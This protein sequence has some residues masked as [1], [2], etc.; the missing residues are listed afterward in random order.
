MSLG[1]IGDIFGCV[2]VGEGTEGG[3][4]TGTGSGRRL[5]LL[6]FKRV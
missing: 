3:G 6:T 1:E 4:V 5:L 2:S